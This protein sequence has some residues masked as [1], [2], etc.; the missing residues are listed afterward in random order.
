MG[1]AGFNR[2]RR[3]RAAKIAEAKAKEKAKA[4]KKAK[5]APAGNNSKKNEDK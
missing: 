2:I 1:L 3:E 5:K 4:S